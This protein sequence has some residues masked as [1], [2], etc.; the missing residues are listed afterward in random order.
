MSK[1][2]ELLAWSG[3]ALYCLRA[4][5]Q[6][7]EEMKKQGMGFHPLGPLGHSVDT[8]ISGLEKAIENMNKATLIK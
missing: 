6:Y 4:Y 3:D 5:R 8:V 1:V 2:K 7:G